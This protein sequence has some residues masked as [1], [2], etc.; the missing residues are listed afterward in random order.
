MDSFSNMGGL[1]AGLL[2]GVSLVPAARYNKK[3]HVIGLW[4]IRCGSLVVFIIVFVVLLDTFYNTDRPD[5]VSKAG[6]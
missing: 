6:A 5:E 2:L 1:L 4:A 3:W